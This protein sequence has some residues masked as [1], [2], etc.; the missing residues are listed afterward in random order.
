MNLFINAVSKVWHL[1]FFDENKNILFEEKIEVAWNESSKLTQKIDDFIA[2]NNIE[3]KN[4]KN[5]V[6]VSWPWSFTWVRA[7]CLIVNTISFAVW[8]KITDISFFDLFDKYP[9]AKSSSKRDLFVKY[10][11]SDSIE[12]IKNED[13]IKYLKTNNINKIYWDLNDNIFGDDLK[14]DASINYSEI[15]KNIVFKDKTRIEPLYIKKPSIG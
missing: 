13:F 3:Y 1:L 12:I 11:K 15:I 9:I 4:I 6:V 2:K 8:S 10:S 5:I 7:I 14:L